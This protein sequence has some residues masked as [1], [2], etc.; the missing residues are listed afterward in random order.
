MRVWALRCLDRAGTAGSADFGHLGAIAAAAAIRAGV[1]AEVEVPILNGAVHLPTLGRLIVHP[2]SGQSGNLGAG[3]EPSTVTVRV[4]GGV[5]SIMSGPQ[6]QAVRSVPMPDFA[7][8]RM[9]LEDTDP[10]RDTH[11]W[12][13]TSRLAD[14]E[15]AMWLRAIPAAWAI[16]LR[17][18]ADYAPAIAAGLSTIV[19]MAPSASRN[20]VSSTARHAYGSIGACLPVPRFGRT[21]PDAATLAL[22][23]I[24]EFQHGKL[25]AV[26]DMADLHDPADKRLFEAPWRPDPRPLEGLLQGTYAHVGV[27]DYWRV[28]RLTAPIEEE[29]AHANSEF[30]RW[31]GHTVRSVEVLAG[32]GSLTAIGVRFA[33]AMRE[34]L[35]PW[36]TEASL[37]SVPS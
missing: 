26:M 22:L 7:T 6:W 27:T 31:L 14:S 28:R 23:C 25:G 37:T 3:P 35:E 19:P 10:Y 13:V 21:E 24:H 5:C 20:D 32:S 33:D 11:Q 1:D 16:L 36:L 17:D 34:T 30:R 18:H 8:G 4:T 15:A 12:A 9:V 2:A 29:R